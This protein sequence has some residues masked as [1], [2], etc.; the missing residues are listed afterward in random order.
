MKQIERLISRVV[1]LVEDNKGQ[2]ITLSI[3]VDGAGNIVGWQVNQSRLESCAIMSVTTE[4]ANPARK[5]S[6]DTKG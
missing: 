4:A 2:L 6:S 1:Q 3:V 5:K